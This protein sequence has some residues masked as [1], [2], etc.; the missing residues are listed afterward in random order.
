[1]CGRFE[2]RGAAPKPL[3][4]EKTDSVEFFSW[5]G[6]FPNE[7]TP[8]HFCLGVEVGIEEVEAFFSI[9]PAKLGK[10][11]GAW[12]VALL[13]GTFNEPTSI[14]K[15]S[16]FCPW[17]ILALKP[18]VYLVQPLRLL[19]HTSF[20]STFLLSA[21]PKPTPFRGSWSSNFPQPLGPGHV[22]ELVS[23]WLPTLAGLGFPGLVAEFP[24]YAS[25]NCKI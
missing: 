15:L 3:H 2:D 19:P 23:C 13:F 22:K 25:V 12:V 20:Q 16:S 21:P 14:S 5:A 18:W 7:M 9:P 6:Q 17:W 8:P 11:D 1:M 10:G 4:W 24:L